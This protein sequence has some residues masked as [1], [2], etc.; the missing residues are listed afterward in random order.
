MKNEA[1][2]YRFRDIIAYF[3]RVKK[4]TWQW[5]RPFQGQFVIQWVT[6]RDHAHFRDDLS[7]VGW[8]LLRSTH[9]PN[10][11]CLLLSATT[12][13]FEFN[14]GQTVKILVFSHPLGDLGVTHRV[15]LR[16]GW[17]R[18]VDFLLV[19]FKRFSLALTAEALLS[20][21]CRNRR[22]LKRWVTLS[23]KYR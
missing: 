17:K 6:W 13:L 5:P 22:F 7:S 16:L 4:V 10:L 12:F 15:H 20:E 2:L 1:I 8:D 23:A 21:I 18:I 14:R 11:K 9:T 19:M 3:A